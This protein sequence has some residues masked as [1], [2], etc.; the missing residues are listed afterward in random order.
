[1]ML[2]SMPI[3]VPITRTSDIR[4]MHEVK[5]ATNAPLV[6]PYVAAKA[7]SRSSR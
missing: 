7:T 4:A 6:N 5:T 3:L 2:Y 1:M